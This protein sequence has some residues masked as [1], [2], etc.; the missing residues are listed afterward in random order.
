ML[1]RDAAGKTHG[2]RL[3]LGGI[4]PRHDRTN[5]VDRGRRRLDLAEVERGLEH[6]EAARTLLL[7]RAGLLP[8]G[9]RP[10]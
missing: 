5:P 4:E 3:G 10:I 2:N 6:D 1:H 9:K 8:D 7:R